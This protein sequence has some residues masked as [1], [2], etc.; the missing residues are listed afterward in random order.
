VLK[1]P[2]IGNNLVAR[3]IF[4]E[5]AGHLREKEISIIVGARQVGKTTLLLQLREYLLRKKI[6]KEEEI[7]LFN[8]DLISDLELFASQKEFIGYLKAETV[9]KKRMFLFVDEVQRIKNPGLFLRGFMTWAYPL[10]WY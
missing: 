7:K 5:V 9:G 1:S 6:A 10:S 2:C 4:S 3:E 8:L